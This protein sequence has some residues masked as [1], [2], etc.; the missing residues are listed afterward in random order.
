MA[1]AVAEAVVSL[2]LQAPRPF[3]YGVDSR[4]TAGQR[5]PKWIRECKRYLS[6]SGMINPTQRLDTLLY[7]VGSDVSDIY[8]TMTTTAKTFDE[9]YGPF[10]TDE[11]SGLRIFQFQSDATKA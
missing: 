10:P 8:E 2:N 9:A 6:S 5:W 7:V 11:K 1:V 3:E 4:A